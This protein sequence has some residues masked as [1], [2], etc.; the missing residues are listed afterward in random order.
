MKKWKMN[1]DQLSYYV[2]TTYLLHPPLL[3]AKLKAY[4]FQ[5][6]AIGL[7]RSYFS[8]RWNRVRIGADTTRDWWKTERGC[9]QG[10]NF[11]PLMRNVFQ[12]NLIYVQHTN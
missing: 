9:P 3:L 1:E 7:M 12:N 6:S 8:E 11:G 4:G 2:F 5:D 10:P